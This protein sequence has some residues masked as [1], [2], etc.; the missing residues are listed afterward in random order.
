MQI[1]HLR[2]SVDAATDFFQSVAQIKRKLQL[3]QDVG[4]GYIRLGVRATW[5]AGGVAHGIKFAKCLQ[6]RGTGRTIYVLG[7]PTTGWHI[8]DVSLLIKG[9][10]SIFVNGDSVIVIV[11]NL[12]LIKV[13]DYIVDIGP[14]GGD[15]GGEIVAEGTLKDIIDN[16][17]SYTGEFLSKII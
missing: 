5:L 15:S 2:M 3:M 11:H 7:C 13:A 8:H 9:L 16:K 10:D 4:L 6:K 17:K 12:E 14:D 1:V